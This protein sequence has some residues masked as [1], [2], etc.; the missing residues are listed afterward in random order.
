MPNAAHPEGGATHRSGAVARMVRMPVATLR[1]WERRYQLCSPA[2]TPSG[3]RLYSAADV[4]RIALLKQLTE[5]GHAI[6]SLAALDMAQLQAVAATHAAA[7]TGTLRADEPVA[8][9]PSWRVAVVGAALARRLQRPALRRRLLRPLEVL[10]PFDDLAQA[11]AGMAG[12]AV[13]LLLVQ[14]PTLQDDWLEHWNRITPR[15]LRTAVLFRF[16]SESVCEQLAAAGVDLL[17]EPPSDTA[18]GQW[19]HALDTSEV[20]PGTVTAPAQATWPTLEAIPA[21]RWDDAAL[22]DI[23]GLSTT[24]A[25]ECPKHIAELLMQLSHFESYSAQCANRSVADAVLHTYLSQV[26]AASRARFEEALE[27]V[28]IHEGLLLARPVQDAPPTKT[29]PSRP[30]VG[31]AGG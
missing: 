28:A 10:G 18:L 19:L 29:N 9:G 24:I 26:A 11:S 7:I 13:D 3:Q 6:G 20:Q 12:A 2:L 1:V 8:A 15:P 27:R 16:A 21:R 22:A 25:C 14:A 31:G 4:R 23:A 17:R 5:L 30:E